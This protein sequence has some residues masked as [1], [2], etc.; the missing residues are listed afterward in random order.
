MTSV[1]Q[2]SGSREIY[3][4][5]HPS[6]ISIDDI[7]QF[8][9]FNNY[10][11][12]AILQE[13]GT[14]NNSTASSNSSYDYDRSVSP[15]IVNNMTAS[16]PNT[17]A[18][19][20]PN[21]YPFHDS[22]I[23]SMKITETQK[24]VEDGPRRK[25]SI[26]R[27]RFQTSG[28]RDV[29]HLASHGTKTKKLA[30]I[31]HK[32]K[33]LTR[34]H[35]DSNSHINYI[36]ETSSSEH[37]DFGTNDISIDDMPTK[38]S[39]AYAE[40]ANQIVQNS[41]QY[42]STPSVFIKGSPSPNHLY[43]NINSSGSQIS[44]SV[45]DGEEYF[46]LN[47]GNDTGYDVSTNFPGVD[48]PSDSGSQN[49]YI[50]SSSLLFTSAES[51]L[52]HQP[53]LKGNDS[54]LDKSDVLGFAPPKPHPLKA[55]SMNNFEDDHSEI[56]S[57]LVSPL[58]PS[59]FQLP[60]WSRSAKGHSSVSNI[61]T[62]N[63]NN[64][65]CE[66]DRSVT[67]PLHESSS[68]EQMALSSQYISN[69]GNRESQLS[70]ATIDIDD[71][72]DIEIPE[73]KRPYASPNQDETDNGPKAT[74]FPTDETL[75]IDS[76]INFHNNDDCATLNIDD[77]F[78]IDQNS[79]MNIDDDDD[80]A[81]AQIK[82][83][84]EKIKE[85]DKKNGFSP[86]KS[87]HSQESEKPT[88]TNDSLDINENNIDLDHYTIYTSFPQ[89]SQKQQQP[90]SH[91]AQ[92][93]P[94]RRAPTVSRKF[95][96]TSINTKLDLFITNINSQVDLNKI[97]EGNAANEDMVE[98]ETP[99]IEDEIDN[100]IVRESMASATDFDVISQVKEDEDF[101]PYKVLTENP[102]SPLY[103]QKSQDNTGIYSSLG[104][105][106]TDSLNDGK[107]SYYAHSRENSEDL[108]E[109]QF[110][111]MSGNNENIQHRRQFSEIVALDNPFSSQKLATSS[112]DVGETGKGHDSPDFFGNLDISSNDFFSDIVNEANDR[113][114]SLSI[115][116]STDSFGMN[117][118][119]LDDSD[120]IANRNSNISSS[121]SADSADTT[122][123]TDS[124]QS[125]VLSPP[126]PQMINDSQESV[127]M[128]S[129][130]MKS[131]LKMISGSIYNPFGTKMAVNPFDSKSDLIA[132]DVEVICEDES[133]IQ[134]SS[135]S[136][137]S[138]HQ[139]R[140]AS[141][142]VSLQEQKQIIREK[143][144]QKL[145]QQQ[146][147]QQQ[148]ISIEYHEQASRKFNVGSMYTGPRHGYGYIDASSHASNC[149]RNTRSKKQMSVS[150]SKHKSSNPNLRS[151]KS[152][153]VS[154]D[155]NG[156]SSAPPLPQFDNF[157]DYNDNEQRQQLSPA[158]SS[159]SA[160]NYQLDSQI[161]EDTADLVLLNKNFFV[162]NGRRTND[163]YH[164][165]KS[166][167]SSRKPSKRHLREDNT[168]GM[169][170]YQ[171]YINT[172]N[173]AKQVSNSNDSSRRD[174][175]A[176]TVVR[177]TVY[178]E[179]ARNDVEVSNEGKSIIDIYNKYQKKDPSLF[180]STT[181][182]AKDIS[183]VKL[184]E[185]L[186]VGV[187]EARYSR[188]SS[189]RSSGLSTLRS[190][191]VSSAM[192]YS[193]GETSDIIEEPSFER[194][195]INSSHVGS[196]SGSSSVS[197]ITMNGASKASAA[198]KVDKM[199]NNGSPYKS[200]LELNGSTKD[201]LERT[202]KYYSSSNVSVSIRSSSDASEPPNIKFQKKTSPLLKNGPNT[203]SPLAE[204]P[205]NINYP[206]IGPNNAASPRFGSPNVNLSRMGS[207]NVP[208]PKL[209]YG[210]GSPVINPHGLSMMVTSQSGRSNTEMAKSEMS[211][212]KSLGYHKMLPDLGSPGFGLPLFAS[213]S[214]L[215]NSPKMVGVGS[216][217]SD[218]SPK[219]TYNTSG[220][221]IGSPATPE[222]PQK[223]SMNHNSTR[224][225]PRTT[226]MSP[227][228]TN[229]ISD[230][231]T[232]S[233]S[234]YSALTAPFPIAGGDFNLGA[235][236]PMLPHLPQ[237]P[238]SNS[239]IDNRNIS[240]DVIID[241][242][243]QGLDFQVDSESVAVEENALGIETHKRSSLMRMVS[244]EDLPNADTM[245]DIFENLNYNQ[246]ITY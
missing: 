171:K 90:F 205:S 8:Q 178:H 58:T 166:D 5:L 22:Q 7:D 162:T 156:H 51:N 213:G 39:I 62:L 73:R 145:Q 143:R 23:Y 68:F 41:P 199:I 170:A 234:S 66:N 226:V 78:N 34:K 152:S 125:S 198:S 124:P 81:Y 32:F 181:V 95:K 80:T 83:V 204:S 176:S 29:S 187:N 131:D 201:L 224:N 141:G 169:T 35:L 50:T 177:N 142:N 4:N 189:N 184:D 82:Q 54:H 19:S 132:G 192:D 128:V 17:S 214:P 9:E 99:Y 185:S 202:N 65:N 223:A 215:V 107:S 110:M 48:L 229:Q 36:E 207:F 24:S 217:I 72:P 105:D 155:N 236:A 137:S 237:I 123:T 150:M 20:T 227:R 33:K 172:K 149:R 104:V 174:S 103:N 122:D 102:Y 197:T 193:I 188:S 88:S 26:F 55:F 144:L 69:N 40:P 67:S 167:S 244:V 3:L 196:T 116:E 47:I 153:L 168:T 233:M 109:N 74:A 209:K 222:V 56:H 11:D 16:T 94:A 79:T 228:Q 2:G 161:D 186:F 139:P 30:S 76:S 240:T 77:T 86:Q 100:N 220:Y 163:I 57:N 206:G 230:R 1:A 119:V 14:D 182:T 93:T 6:T 75:N 12:K 235:D 120:M 246:G 31:G 52:L 101:N 135:N 140:S 138:S 84:M 59:T 165:M 13:N 97:V 112:K 63:N 118:A 108:H 89:T 194:F 175:V 195:S 200:S 117:D 130:S 136:I 15:D 216:P 64:N 218:N 203:S 180:R 238:L 37:L 179:I 61:L 164:T 133:E 25:P 158:L 91:S 148:Q 183:E 121:S 71:S 96:T 211:T 245:Q 241:M 126:A 129:H 127:N 191:T 115:E 221:Y 232:K 190:S 10:L 111:K 53:N 243:T 18:D 45:N 43:S 85:I 70:A 147:Q 106:S 28:N 160:G 134:E 42:S 219:V 231:Y 157:Y 173:S 27:K 154:G 44:S 38:T 151:R 159:S 212:P 208:S 98:L 46:Q 49:E 113:I 239:P 225:S 92:S 87:L 60:Q 21:D 146:K 242:K 210:K 114:N